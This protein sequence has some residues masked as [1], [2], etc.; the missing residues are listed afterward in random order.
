M[1]VSPRGV[2]HRRRY[3]GG[4]IGLAL[5]LWAREKRPSRVVR[6]R[7]NPDRVLGASA[8]PRWRTLH[9]WARAAPRLWPSLRLISEASLPRIREVASQIVAALVAKSGTD[10]IGVR[11]AF[12]A[13]AHVR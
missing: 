1:I 9:R 10:R 6:E 13:G 7:V 12:V 5:F 11:E 2:L 4:A 8:A 3:F